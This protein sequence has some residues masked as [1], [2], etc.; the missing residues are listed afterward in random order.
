M[1][2]EMPPFIAIHIAGREA[3]I[4]GARYLRP[5][6]KGEYA[7]EYQDIIMI[8]IP[9]FIQIN[10]DVARSFVSERISDGKFLGCENSVWIIT[11]ENKAKLIADSETAEAA[12][13][14]NRERM[15]ELEEKDIKFKK[16]SGF[17]FKCGTWCYGDC[18][19]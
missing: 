18:G 13:K 12:K 8:A 16:E 4:S 5:D 15:R 2:T 1:K 10:R 17:C 19:A 3:E 9:P 11:E 6:E 14:V 7:K